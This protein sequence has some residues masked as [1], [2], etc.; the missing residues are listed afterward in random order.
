MTTMKVILMVSALTNATCM[1]LPLPR[2]CLFATDLCYSTEPRSVTVPVQ[3]YFYSNTTTRGGTFLQYKYQDK[4]ACAQNPNSLWDKIK[5]S[6]VWTFNK[7]HQ[8]IFD[9]EPRFPNK[10]ADYIFHLASISCWPPAQ[11]CGSQTGFWLQGFARVAHITRE[12]G[13]RLSIG[14]L[15]FCAL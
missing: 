9:S 6:F 7:T 2:S 12:G 3:Q 13:A 14:C 1:L 4:V 15:H 10:I 11:R 5:D 8:T